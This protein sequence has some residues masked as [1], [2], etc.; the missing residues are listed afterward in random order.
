MKIQTTFPPKEQGMYVCY[1]KNDTYPDDFKYPEKILLMWMHNNNGKWGYPS[2]DQDFRGTVYGYIGP[3]P[4]PKISELRKTKKKFAIGKIDSVT[5]HSF[6]FGP[7]DSLKEAKEVYGAEGQCICVI[8]GD[9]YPKILRV[10][11]SNNDQWISF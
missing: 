6:I 8:K 2:S 10:W 11:D 1:V 4:A 9:T 3:L 5:F 7:F